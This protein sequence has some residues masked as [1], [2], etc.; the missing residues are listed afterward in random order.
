MDERATKQIQ[1]F[2]NQQKELIDTLI[3]Q[4]DG[5]IEPMVE[6]SNFIIKRQRTIT[7]AIKWE[8]KND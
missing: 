6:T 7:N 3:L 2:L 1:Y 8:L 5:E 4:L